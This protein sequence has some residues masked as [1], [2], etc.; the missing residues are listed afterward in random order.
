MTLPPEALAEIA[1]RAV[2]PLPGARKLIAL[3][4]PPGAG[5]TTMAAHLAKALQGAGRGAVVVPMDGFHLDNRVLNARGLS[6]RK[7]APETFDAAG[8]CHL[9]ARIAAGEADIAY[10]IFDRTRDIAIA[11][12]ACLS[13]ETEFV[14]FEGNYLLLDA[15]PWRDLARHWTYT[16]WIGTD[17]TDLD[18]RLMRRWRDEGLSDHS[19]RLKLDGNDLP[20]I[21][22]VL[23]HSVAAD[24]DLS[25]TGSRP[26]DG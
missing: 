11:G 18:A 9:V 8:F 1:L 5:K 19:A 14:L 13:A 12:A 21:R 10:P 7:G 4:G 26:P 25:A 6:D 22:L 24:L 20:N 2:L 17:L 15:A 23:D 16:I 3:A